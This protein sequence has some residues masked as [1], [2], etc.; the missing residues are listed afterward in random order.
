M[1][2]RIRGTSHRHAWPSTVPRAA[3]LYL[4][5]TLACILWPVGYSSEQA[6]DRSA[7]LPW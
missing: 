7:R 4:D 1:G 2:R 6:G 3:R 5:L